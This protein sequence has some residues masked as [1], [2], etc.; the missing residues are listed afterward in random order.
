MLNPDHLVGA[1]IEIGYK[2]RIEIPA[3]ELNLPPDTYIAKYRIGVFRPV[4]PIHARKGD[5]VYWTIVN[6]TDD[7]RD[8]R[9]DDFSPSEP[10]SFSAGKSA[11]MEAK[12]DLKQIKSRVKADAEERVYTYRVFIDN[13]LA[14]DPELDIES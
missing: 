8:V 13:E 14:L 6:Y 11:R 2:P 5:E 1:T 10:I 3:K 7:T 12:G 9:V 4:A